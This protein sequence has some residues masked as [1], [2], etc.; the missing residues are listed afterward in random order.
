MK[1]KFTKI[2]GDVITTM[3]E[4][5]MKNVLSIRLIPYEPKPERAERKHRC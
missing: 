5:P 4:V 2:S 3:L 1:I